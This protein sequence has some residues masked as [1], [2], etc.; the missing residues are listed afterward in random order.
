MVARLLLFLERAHARASSRYWKDVDGH[1]FVAIVEIKSVFNL[2]QS[3]EGKGRR[4]RASSCA[5]FWARM[6]VKAIINFC[7]YFIY[8]CCIRIELISCGISK[9]NLYVIVFWQRSCCNHPCFAMTQQYSVRLLM[10]HSSKA[11]KLSIGEHRFTR[12]GRNN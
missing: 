3:T 11:L 5:K 1:S 12:R 4:R 10:H 8:C 2:E 9:S 7:R 6:Y